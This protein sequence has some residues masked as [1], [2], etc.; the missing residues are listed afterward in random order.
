MKEEDNVDRLFTF[1]RHAGKGGSPSMPAGFAEKILQQHRNRVQEN[2]AFLQDF[3]IVRC[4]RADHSG[5]RA[6][7]KHRDE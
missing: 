2:K 6:R 7:N 3:D 1:A 4:N 5:D